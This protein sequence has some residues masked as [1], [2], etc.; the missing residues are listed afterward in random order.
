[1]KQS[2]MSAFIL[3]MAT[4]FAHAGGL[5]AVDEC[6]NPRNADGSC[7][8]VGVVIP[9][10]SARSLGGLGAGGAVAAG[11]AVLAAA[12]L[13]ASSNDSNSGSH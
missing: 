11:V 7:P 4:S 12:A 3:L 10:G 1:M 13:I 2:V 8:T 5:G 6:E 9:V